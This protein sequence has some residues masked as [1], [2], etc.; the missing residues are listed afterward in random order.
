ME[1]VG[2]P[3]ES[4]LYQA[5]T[6]Q[7]D[8]WSKM[9]SKEAER[10]SAQ[11]LIWLRDWISLG[12]VWVS[13]EKKR[14]LEEEYASQWSAE[15]GIRVNTSKGLDD[16]WTTRKYDP[17]GLWAYQ[18][19]TKVRVKGQRN[20]IDV[21]IEQELP[22]GLSVATQADRKTLIRRT[23]FDLTGLP[24]S[25]EQANDFLNDPGRMKKRFRM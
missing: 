24:P 14:E 25:P 5:A 21:L 2:K 18:P 20:P 15:D 7:N 11:Q 22:I 3:N 9:P 19:V 23:T 8:D 12:A 17:A 6:R 13:N 4:P 10:L 16:N 1:T